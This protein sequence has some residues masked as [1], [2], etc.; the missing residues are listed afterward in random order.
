VFALPG[1]LTRQGGFRMAVCLDEFQQIRNFDS[2]TVEAALRNEVQKQRT[3]GYVFAGSQPTLMDAMLAPKRPFY[4]AGPRVFLDKIPAGAWRVF[5]ARQFAR[6]GRDLTPQA[7]EVL[8]RAA[9]LIPYDVQ[10]VAHELWDFAEL[11]DRRRLEVGD[12][13]DVLDRL[14]A[15]QGTYYE[16]Q[17]QQ[18]A[19][20][21]RAVLQALAHR[22]S[23]GLLSQ[24]VRS[25]WRL[26]AASTVQ[27]ALQAL[28][29][30]DILDRYQGRYFL[31]DPL[32]GRWIER[33]G[34]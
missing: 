24:E 7:M 30:Q 29:K 23:E 5:I 17:W 22:G 3:V 13:E 2:G 6:R 27:K 14:L 31:L 25:T 18:L 10:R 1:L 15:G 9:D 19:P 16:R 12:V 20:R 34:G 4:K 32:F 33:M 21:Q 8:L 28:E 26:G 11:R